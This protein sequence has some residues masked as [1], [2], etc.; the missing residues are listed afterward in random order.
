MRVRAPRRPVEIVCLISPHRPVWS[1]PAGEEFEIRAEGASFDNRIDL[2][3]LAAVLAFARGDVVDLTAPGCPGPS[4][5]ATNPEQHELGD[6]AEI[7][8]DPAPVAATVPAH[9]VPHE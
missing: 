9:L 7:K 8:A 4:V 3:R 5:F 2:V 1:N 6:I